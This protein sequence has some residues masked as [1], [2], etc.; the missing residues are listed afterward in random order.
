MGALEIDDHHPSLSAEEKQATLEQ[1]LQARSG[2]YHARLED[3]N[4]ERPERCSHATGEAFYF[5]NW[6]FNA[7]GII[8]ER[9]TLLSLVTAFKEWITDPLGMQHFRVE[10]V[11]YYTGDASVF[12]PIDFEIQRETGISP[13]VGERSLF[14]TNSKPQ[15]FSQL[16]PRAGIE[17]AR[18]Y[19][20]T[21]LSRMRL[22]IPPP[23]HVDR[24]ELHEVYPF[25]IRW[26]RML[27]L[28]PF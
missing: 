11:I 21:I 14:I 27:A 9:L 2:I 17:P 19:G 16:V 15:H 26:A 3:S 12:P 7:A 4:P 18:P 10:G 13:T 25:K 22:P 8:F 23:R 1:P 28:T 6:S 20:H 24:P 5:N